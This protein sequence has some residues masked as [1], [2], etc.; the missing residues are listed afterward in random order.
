MFGCRRTGR[1]IDPAQN[2]VN[3]FHL[4]NIGIQLL[5]SAVNRIAL[6]VKLVSD[7]LLISRMLLT[8]IWGQVDT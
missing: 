6:D 3:A 7:R 4:L 8:R 2:Q 1:G 5:M